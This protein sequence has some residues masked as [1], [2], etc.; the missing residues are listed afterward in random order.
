MSRFKAAHVVSRG[1]WPPAILVYVCII[2]CKVL[3]RFWPYFS[4]LSYNKYFF[5]RPHPEKPLVGILEEVTD[6]VESIRISGNCTYGGR[7]QV[8]RSLS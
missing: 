4:K 6:D 8:D 3:F 1:A 5:S 2:G 7:S